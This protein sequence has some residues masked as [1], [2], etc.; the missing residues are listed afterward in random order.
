MNISQVLNYVTHVIF[1][2]DGLLLDTERVY[3]YGIST[4]LKKYGCEY[5]DDVKA[6]VLG[7]Q[8]PDMMKILFR[9]TKLSESGKT[10]DE[11]YKEIVDTYTPLMS[12]AEWM[13]GALRLINHLH[14]HNIPFAIATSSAKESFE[15]KTSR[16]KDTLKLFHHVVLGSAD[17]EVKQGKPAPDVFLVAAK[18]FDEKPQPSKCLVFEDAP[19][20]VLGA[21][22]AGMS[23]V[24]VP[25]PT[26]PKHRTEAADL[27]LN[28]LEE[29][30]P[31]L[32]GLPPFEDK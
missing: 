7:S 3:K 10:K 2:M 8:P 17:P 28:S 26:V 15:L 13:P 12:S 30:K 31:E 9:E 22:A 4:V 21:K 27:V 14:K 6:M 16:H 5:P 29:F 32:Y 18:R 25:D 23:C 19:N 20:G 11:V 24:M 1:D